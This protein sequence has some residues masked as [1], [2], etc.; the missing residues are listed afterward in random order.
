M[1]HGTTSIDLDL[2]KPVDATLPL[3][4][5]SSIADS[6][7]QTLR[8]DIDDIMHAY[9]KSYWRAMW[10]VGGGMALGH[11]L[12]SIQRALLHNQYISDGFFIA[13]LTVGPV[14]ACIVGLYGGGCQIEA[15]T[16]HTLGRFQSL[17]AD[18]NQHSM[19]LPS[20][21]FHL[22]TEKSYSRGGGEHADHRHSMLPYRYYLEILHPA[23]QRPNGTST[24]YYH[25]VS[26]KYHDGN[27]AM[28]TIQVRLLDD[29][30]LDQLKDRLSV[31]EEYDK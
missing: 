16:K 17:C 14:V 3:S 12:L 18:M 31:G 4:L 10:I 29:D 25:D 28:K 23:Y 11:L 8:Q 19:V 27:N 22:R 9:N 1:Q 24:S 2:G 13:F 21:T 6:Q 15:A 30:R 7:W 26:P 5:R 20:V